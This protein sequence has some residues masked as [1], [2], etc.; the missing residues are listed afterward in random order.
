M[1][2]DLYEY[3]VSEIREQLAAAAGWENILSS[4]GVTFVDIDDGE[5]RK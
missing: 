5:G 3:L 4:M 2:R 1:E